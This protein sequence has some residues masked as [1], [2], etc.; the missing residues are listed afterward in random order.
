MWDRRSPCEKVKKVNPY[1]GGRDRVDWEM[2]TE[3]RER[4]GW[5][6]LTDELLRYGTALIGFIGPV[7]HLL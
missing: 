6:Q 4:G 5:L 2:V 7:F 1:A 3:V